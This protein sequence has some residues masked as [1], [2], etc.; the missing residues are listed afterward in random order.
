MCPGRD[1]HSSSGSALEAPSYIPTSRGS[2]PLLVII[3][4][5][6]VSPA[7]LSILAPPLKTGATLKTVQSAAPPPPGLLFPFPSRLDTHLCKM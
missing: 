6:F 3:F 5:Y 7:T 1:S 4:N 2:N